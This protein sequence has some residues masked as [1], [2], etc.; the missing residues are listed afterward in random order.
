MYQ[1]QRHYLLINDNT[2]GIAIHDKWSNN[3]N[4]MSGTIV[5]SHVT[6]R[7][8]NS[9]RSNCHQDRLPSR[10]VVSKKDKERLRI[11]VL[12]SKITGVMNHPVLSHRNR[13]NRVGRIDLIRR[14]HGH[15]KMEG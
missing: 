2:Q 10:T 14:V 9:I 7:C 5:S 13:Q 3:A 12:A 8:V 4:F 11:E 1:P 6:Q 15:R